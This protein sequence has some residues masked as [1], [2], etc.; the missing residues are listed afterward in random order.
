MMFF[1]LNAPTKIT[2]KKI[3]SRIII[4]TINIANTG[5][6]IKDYFKITSFQKEKKTFSRYKLL[7]SW[8][9][10]FIKI[11]FFSLLLKALLQKMIKYVFI[12]ELFF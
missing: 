4:I 2:L 3:R 9:Q 7:K 12:K 8:M 10:N 1:I 5:E 11:I 6:T